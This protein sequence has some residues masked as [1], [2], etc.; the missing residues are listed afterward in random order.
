M[1]LGLVVSKDYIYRMVPPSEEN[2]YVDQLF[3]LD[4]VK[5]LMQFVPN[6]EINQLK[7]GMELN[8]IKIKYGGVFLV[9]TKITS[10]EGYKWEHCFIY[11]SDYLDKDT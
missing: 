5:K 4:E 9:C 7:G 3:Q 2:P 6:F 1:C 11:D 10:K 8:L